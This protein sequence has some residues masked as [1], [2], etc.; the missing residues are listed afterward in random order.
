[1]QKR[2]IAASGCGIAIVHK[3]NSEGSPAFRIYQRIFCDFHVTHVYAHAALLDEILDHIRGC[4]RGNRF[5]CGSSGSGIATTATIHVR[6][7]KC[8]S[9]LV[10]FDNLYHAN[11]CILALE[12]GIHCQLGNIASSNTT[13]RRI[14][15]KGNVPYISLLTI[16]ARSCDAD[17]VNA[18]DSFD[19]SLHLGRRGIVLDR[20]GRIHKEISAEGIA[21]H[22]RLP[23]ACRRAEKRQIFISVADQTCYIAI[24]FPKG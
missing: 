22:D 20:L 15:E 18:I 23:R 17:I 24:V 9:N 2:S 16:W 10:A 8:P 13:T 1:M 5:C 19:Y 7:S 3:R 14:G 6:Q 21:I 12:R 4:V 11:C